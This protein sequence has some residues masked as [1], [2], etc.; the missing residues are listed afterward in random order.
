MKV[1]HESST[2]KLHVSEHVFAIEG[3]RRKEKQQVA[4][5]LTALKEEKGERKE[6]PKAET[7]PRLSL[8]LPTILSFLLSSFSS[9]VAEREGGRS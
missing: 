3:R 4:S 1:L 9:L 7:F 8:S 2:T 6:G 5:A